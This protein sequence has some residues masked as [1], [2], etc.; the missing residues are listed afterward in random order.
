MKAAVSLEMVILLVLIIAA[1]MIVGSMLISTTQNATE[2]MENKTSTI[3]SRIEKAC[4]DDTDCEFGER[5]VR[6]VCKG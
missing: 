2:K 5:C 3:I 4:I 6:G 1:V